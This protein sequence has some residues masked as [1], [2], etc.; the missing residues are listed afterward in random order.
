MFS[1]TIEHVNSKNEIR[2]RNR[3]TRKK[4]GVS[5]E[6]SKVGTVPRQKLKLGPTVP[7][8]SYAPRQWMN[9]TNLSYTYNPSEAEYEK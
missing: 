7:A 2:Q 5:G 8:G 4:R 9:L 6:R 3:R 1:L